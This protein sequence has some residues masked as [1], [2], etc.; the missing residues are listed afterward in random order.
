MWL[1]PPWKPILFPWYPRRWKCL[2][3]CVSQHAPHFLTAA[4]NRCLWAALVMVTAVA[5]PLK[6][7]F[8]ND[9][10]RPP[11]IRT[12]CKNRNINDS[13]RSCFLFFFYWFNWPFIHSFV[14]YPHFFLHLISLWYIVFSMDL[15]CLAVF[16]ISPISSALLCFLYCRSCWANSDWFFFFFLWKSSSLPS[17]SLPWSTGQCCM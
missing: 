9:C 2:V 12:H 8:V 13:F 10:L 11:W 15:C 6:R 1:P 3:C 14:L 7:P 4:L 17:T 5:M 16:L